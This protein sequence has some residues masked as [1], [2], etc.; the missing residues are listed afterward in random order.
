M[1]SAEKARLAREE[2]A[3]K[4]REGWERFKS[5]IDSA[6]ALVLDVAVIITTIAIV[7]VG[8]LVMIGAGK[9]DFY[10]WLLLP[11]GVLIGAQWLRSYITGVPIYDTNLRLG[12]FVAIISAAFLYFIVMLCY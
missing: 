9:Y 11:A 2:G 1:N 12:G 3:K 8:Y 4:R 7:V 10:W 5:G 6:L